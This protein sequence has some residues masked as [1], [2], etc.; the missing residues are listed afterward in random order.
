M[1]S[2]DLLTGEG[3]GGST[4]RGVTKWEAHAGAQLEMTVPGAEVRAVGMGKTARFRVY[5][6]GQG[7]RTWRD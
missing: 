3:Q 4:D 7:S 1:N 6:G 5:L 2:L